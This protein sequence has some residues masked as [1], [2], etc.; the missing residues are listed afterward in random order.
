MEIRE[1]GLSEEKVR[2]ILVRHINRDPELLTGLDN[3][4]L[5]RL[6]EVLVAA[7]ADVFARNNE[8]VESAVKQAEVA[9]R[10]RQRLL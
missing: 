10:S 7:I 9:A 2:E 8:V 1:V 6:V 3:P 4:R 5:E